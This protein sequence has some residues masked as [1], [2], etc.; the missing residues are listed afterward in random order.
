MAYNDFHDRI[1]FSGLVL[2]SGDAVEQIKQ[3]KY[4]DWV[5]SAIMPHNVANL[6]EPLS[7]MAALGWSLT[8]EWGGRPSTVG[9]ETARDSVLTR[10]FAEVTTFCTHPEQTQINVNIA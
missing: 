2:E 5:A 10:R 9:A 1:G 7:D 3:V 6:T 8:K 4:R